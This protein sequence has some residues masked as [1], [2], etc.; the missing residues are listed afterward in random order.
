[1]E[2][3]TTMTLAE[4]IAADLVSAMKAREASVVD[5]LR[6]LRASVKNTEIDKGH[7]LDDEE[8]VAVIRTTQKQ[9]R[10]AAAD[11]RAGKR[12][13]LVAK[14]ET[15]QKVLA[16]YLP[17]ELPDSEI[18]AIVQKVIAEIG[19]VGPKDFGRVMGKAV[20]E[21]KGRA[22]GSKVS[23]MVKAELANG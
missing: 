8:I 13:D 2:F 22:E 19:L 17:A 9:L 3:Q 21:I 20:A 7:V 1:M 16:A 18:K 6:M 23:E 15:E 11:F 5:T 12:E 4:R 10:D 14:A